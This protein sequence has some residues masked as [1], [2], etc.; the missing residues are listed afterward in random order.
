MLMKSLAI[1]TIAACSLIAVLMAF[2]PAR[3]CPDPFHSPDVEYLAT[4]NTYGGRG[5]ET[6]ADIH[7]DAYDDLYLLDVRA[8][9][10]YI[11]TDLAQ[12]SA[13]ISKGEGLVVPSLITVSDKGEIYAV[14]IA[15][16][17]KSARIGVFDFARKR[18]K[19]FDLQGFTGAGHFIP[20]AIAMDGNNRIYLAGDTLPGVVML[21][22]KGAFLRMIRP[23]DK[24]G[25]DPPKPV[26][27]RDI[28]VDAK[29]TIYLLS[30]SMGRVYVYNQKFEFMF[31]FGKKG[32]VAG[33][34]SRPRGIAVDQKG[35]IFISDYMRHS[36]SI[37]EPDGTYIKEFGGRGIG[38]T[39][40]NYPQAI[41]VSENNVLAVGDLF[42]KRVELF[43]I[44][45]QDT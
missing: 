42:N 5:I 26:I 19:T 34:L 10:V 25:D 11:F 36:I 39:W 44:I 20:H 4:I 18:I 43:R 15:A 37:Y 1:K 38:H 30:E 16:G 35:R 32:G 21:D 29:G 7:I 6:P 9:A 28:A 22:E 24:F 14:E 27:I 31:K 45:D 13:M 40:F 3:V 41:A 2:S 17:N 23:E 8:G 33:T 12:E